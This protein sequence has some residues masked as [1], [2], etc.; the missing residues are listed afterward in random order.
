MSKHLCYNAYVASYEATPG[1]SIVDQMQSL[2]IT[3]QHVTPQPMADSV[4]FWNCSNVPEDLPKYISYIELDP[5]KCIG[6]GLS[7]EDAKK[8]EEYE[9]SNKNNKQLEV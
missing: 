5:T 6:W 3:Y 2:G 4:W 8:I 1:G 7:E 9:N